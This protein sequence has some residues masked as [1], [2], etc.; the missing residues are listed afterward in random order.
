MSRH[1][2]EKVDRVTSQG[3]FLFIREGE[4]NGFGCRRFLML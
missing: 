1:A 4:H 3:I 2:L